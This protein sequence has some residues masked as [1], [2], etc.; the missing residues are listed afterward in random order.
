MYCDCDD[1]P[2][3][4]YDNGCYYCN[5]QCSVTCH[6]DI[7]NNCC[8]ELEVDACGICYGDY[9]DDSDCPEQIGCTDPLACNY[10]SDAEEDDGSCSYGYQCCHYNQAGDYY[11]WGFDVCFESE[12]VPQFS[13]TDPSNCGDTGGGDITIGDVNGDGNINVLDIVALAN[14][15]L[16]GG[17]FNP[18]GDVN[19][20]GVHN[21]LDIVA[22][23]N[24]ILNQ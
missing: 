15:I 20:D 2:L 23:A 5:G 22:L 11:Y 19:D 6:R 16:N 14:L 3:P 24:L 12:C 21:I 13:S 4:G 7:L 8:P 17:D 9:T 10:S 18:A 1:N